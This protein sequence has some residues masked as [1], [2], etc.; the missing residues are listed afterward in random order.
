MRDGR[1]D[2]GQK[3]SLSFGSVVQDLLGD[4][5]ETEHAHVSVSSQVFDQ[6]FLNLDKFECR[7]ISFVNAT[8]ALEI[9]DEMLQSE[10][11]LHCCQI[12][13]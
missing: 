11:L 2:Q 10:L 6:A 7:N 5:I 3:F 1:I 8:H 4:V 9:F 13:P 12:F